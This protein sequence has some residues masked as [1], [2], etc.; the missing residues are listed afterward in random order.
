MAHL[1]T[2]MADRAFSEVS[3]FAACS[4]SSGPEPSLQY[5]SLTGIAVRSHMRLL[6][7]GASFCAVTLSE[8]LC[9]KLD[10]SQHVRV[11]DITACRTA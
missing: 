4:L 8:V 1:I 5:I 9:A 2:M 7:R 11:A 10:V 6:S 3:K